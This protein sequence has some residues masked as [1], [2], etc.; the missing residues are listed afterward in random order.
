MICRVIR[1]SRRLVLLCLVLG[2]FLVQMQIEMVGLGQ[3]QA[4]RNEPVYFTIPATLEER[5][6]VLEK[7]IT[8]VARLRQT[9]DNSELARTLNRLSE[10]QLKLNNP[11]AAVAA[12]KEALTLA[13]Q[14]GNKVLLIDILNYIASVYRTLQDNKKA[15]LLLSEAYS[16]SIRLHYRQGEAQSLMETTAVDLQQAGLAKAEVHGQDALRIWEELSDKRGEARSHFYLG[17]TFMRLGKSKEAKASLEKAVVLWRELGELTELASTLIDLN[18]LAMR[19][20]QWQKALSLL[21]E[22][23]PLI[24]DPKAEP[25]I[26]G[27]IASSFGYVYETYGQLEIALGYFKEALVFYRDYAHD[28]SAA[29]DASRKVG[30]VQSR[31]GNFAD[32]VEQIEQGLELAK[33]I[34]D[35]FMAAL[36]HED[37]GTVYLA[38]GQYA[39]AK[40]EFLEAGV[41]YYKVGSRREWARAQTFLG[42]TDYLLGNLTSAENSYRNALKV[43]RSVDDFTSEAALCF[44]LGKVELDRDNLDE[45]GTL[46]KRAIALTEQ[47][48]E[49]AASKELRSSFLAS[50]HDRYETYVEWLMRR[51]SQE[52]DKQFDIEAFE[53]SEM[54]RARSL[55]D[56]LTDYQRELRRVADPGLLVEEAELQR[57]EQQALDKRTKLLS[58][59]GTPEAK[60]KAENE[61]VA[62]RTRYETLQA[63]INTTTK[64]SDLLR[65]KPLRFAEIRTQVTDAE[66]TILEYSLGS[67]KS[68]LWVITPEGLTSYEL[69]DK[70]TIERLGQKLV[71]LLA[72][73]PDGEAQEIELKDTIAEVSRVVLGPI[74][75]KLR[76]SRLIVVADGILQ[77]VP[78]QIL[79]LPQDANEP[80][81]ARHEIVN[82][83]SASTLAVVQKE[84]AS[85]T[86]SSTLMAAFGDPVFASNY[87][88]KIQTSGREQ[89]NDLTADTSRGVQRGAEDRTEDILDPKKIRP[90]FFARRELSE[91]RKLVRDDQSA[92]YMDFDAT[93][94]KLRKLDLSQYRILHFATHGLL[95][96][97][98]PELSGLVL[99]LV[100]RQG[101]S[102]EGFVGLSDIYSLRAPVDLVVLSGCRT[103]LGKDV[104][105]EG[106]I[107]LTRGFMY[108]GAS[109]V[110]ASLW[111]VDDEATAELM[112]RFYT[113]LL[114]G[115]MTPAAA[116]RA[117]QNSVRQKPEWSAPYYWAAFTVQGDFRGVIKAPRA[118]TAQTYETTVAI[119]I[120]L[121]LMT[122]V[123]WSYRRHMR[124]MRPESN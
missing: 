50:V 32:A 123:A 14:S 38:A 27:Q 42:Q 69:P 4:L 39:R 101:H 18:F 108:A 89:T 59:G 96:A 115:G 52:P 48:R 20:G 72:R 35:Q 28:L 43:F 25:Y 53:A 49:N 76:A 1:Q 79:T 95:D 26:A 120:L 71:T 61:L 99:S 105:G 93:R 30:R 6:Q 94:D 112:K 5:R 81:V 98:H 3:T 103:A 124:E 45:A 57:L 2:I 118:T 107:G 78:F 17:E 15:A 51:H 60:A 114:K 29:I 41:Q 104:R 97:K 21:K 82:V 91:L 88:S 58:E 16:L 73:P 7:V 33:K 19:Q 117:A 62:V 22:T 83:P 111:K 121:T 86:S 67:R 36:C 119:V 70:E 9:G 116:L 75:E 110:V 46:L 40:K 90:L 10:I 113:N 13:R 23:Q 64:F 11:D 68:Y 37:L 12:A 106:L 54:G 85:R 44:G 109:T 100:D 66:T 77:Y 63:Q 87:S 31:I 65:P 74:A 34:D 92:I 80:L 122:I 84:A 8:A 55:L 24:T 47:L 56:S 102:I